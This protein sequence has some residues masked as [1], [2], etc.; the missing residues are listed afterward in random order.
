MDKKFCVQT[1]TS[2]KKGF[3]S[4]GHGTQELCRLVC[5]P[6]RGLWPQPTGQ[7]KFSDHYVPVNTQT[8]R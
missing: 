8:V 5:G 4:S 2:V 6:Y 1:D 3:A 7:V